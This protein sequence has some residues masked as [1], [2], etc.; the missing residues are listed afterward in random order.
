MTSKYIAVY[1]LQ[2]SDLPWSFSFAVHKKMQ[3][4]SYFNCN[5]VMR[6]FRQVNSQ[7]QDDTFHKQTKTPTPH[8]MDQ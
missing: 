4:P 5:L 7:L 8:F 2:A 3:A 6:L 1:Y